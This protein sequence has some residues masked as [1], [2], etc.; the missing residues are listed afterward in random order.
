MVGYR[1]DCFSR[2]RY[3]VRVLCSDFAFS[4]CDRLNGPS[5]RCVFIEVSVYAYVMPVADL[6]NK[7]EGAYQI[8]FHP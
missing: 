3:E 5:L 6:R 7:L 4:L 1:S 2:Q 8:I